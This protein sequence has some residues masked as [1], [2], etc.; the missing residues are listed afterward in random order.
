MTPDDAKAVIAPMEQALYAHAAQAEPV[1]RDILAAAHVRLCFP[2]EDLSGG[3]MYWDEALAPLVHAMPD[4]ERRVFLRVAGRDAA[5]HMWVGCAGH[6]MGAWEVPFLDMPPTGQLAHLRFH[7]FFRIEAGQVVEMQAI[8]DLP[9]LMQQARVW[10][11]APAL[12]RDLM[13]PGPASGD[14]LGPHG[15]GGTEA[16][17]QVEEMLAAMIR[18][19]LQGGPDVMEMDRF[20]HPRFTWYG[21]AGIGAM[22]GY[23]GFR[24]HHQIP[25]LSA[26]PDR[27]QHP[28]GI[29]HHFF[30]EGDYAAVT[31][32]PNMAQTIT[33]DGWLGIAPA[34]QSVT[35]RSLDFW[36]LENGLI[37][38]N[39]VLVDL[40]SMYD[41]LGVD[42]LA[43]MRQLAGVAPWT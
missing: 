30:G 9:E 11:M 33:G 41:Q 14:G 3:H 37:R 12:G 36:R 20:W 25:F 17:A 21:P 19:P 5:G 38:E 26:M 10:P 23:A 34:G 28:E 13:A 43:R 8:W 35:L 24:R 27:G 22:R 32:W 18:H 42:V 7:E 1:L 6:Y 15:P 16:C 4:L 39:W 29:T 31:G 40:L 2:F